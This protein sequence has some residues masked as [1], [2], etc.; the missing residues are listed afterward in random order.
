MATLI[1]DKHIGTVNGLQGFTFADLFEFYEK[2]G[3]GEHTII[4]NSPG[5]N[6]G[7]G[8]FI[9][10]FIQSLLTPPI[11]VAVKCQSIATIL[12]LSVPVENRHIV[13]SPNYMIHNPW[14]EM[15]GDADTL[16]IVADQLKDIETS[17]LDFY[18]D[19]TKGMREELREWMQQEKVLGAAELLELGF[20]SK[21]VATPE[22]TPVAEDPAP[23]AYVESGKSLRQIKESN[24]EKFEILNIMSKNEEGQSRVE[25]LVQNLSE[26]FDKIIS[27]KPEIKALTLALLSGE[28]M[29]IVTED[30]LI[31][32]GQQVTIEG[33]SPEN[34]TYETA[35]TAQAITV[36]GGV[37][38]A[39]EEVPQVEVMNLEEV[40][41][42][43]EK[44]MNLVAEKTNA[45][46][47]KQNETIEALQL[48]V[49]A[50][51][52]AKTEQAAKIEEQEKAIEEKELEINNLKKETAST[53]Q[54]MASA[55]SEIEGQPNVWKP[56]TV[57][58]KMKEIREKNRK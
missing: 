48:E 39:I 24:K 4:L 46:I 40:E 20:A 11:M 37:I 43:I 33:K 15:K 17:I 55:N 51:K 45:Q 21:V 3:D 47:T 29:N 41:S 58:E 27:P 14:I 23:V 32:V 25:K 57:R 28:Q 6:V 42:A 8:F 18:V 49:N 52:E 31:Q 44:A 16:K 35:E 50:L 36:E 9:H 53:Y 5:G 30:N 2:N 12:H 38:T 54:P 19:N 22:L 56:T 1:I 26:K 7:E 10:D 34:G 13:D